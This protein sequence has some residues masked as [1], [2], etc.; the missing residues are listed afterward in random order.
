MR[1]RT[2]ISCFV[3]LA[4]MA[5][6]AI[7]FD[8]FITVKD[9]E[10]KP[11]GNAAVIIYLEGDPIDSGQTGANGVFKT[12]LEAGINYHI[13]ASK[14]DAT[15]QWFGRD[16]NKITITIQ[17]SRMPSPSDEQPTPPPNEEEPMPSSRPWDPFSH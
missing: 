9:T 17:G 11:V 3:F 5:Q 16:Q 10:R 12:N 6:P 7:S 1:L 8:A 4:I 15:G 14:S 2:A 13:E